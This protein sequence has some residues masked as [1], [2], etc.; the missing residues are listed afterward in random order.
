MNLIITCA[1]HMEPE[2]SEEICAI[3]EKMG[4]PKASA[5]ITDMPGILT[6][7]TMLDPF[8]IIRETHQKICDEPWHIRYCLRMI[9]IQNTTK[10]DIK[11]I[12]KCVESIREKILEKDTYRISIEKRNSNV[13]SQELIINIA[14][15]IPNKVSLEKPDKTI[16]IEILGS[17]TGIAITQKGDVL[18]V[19]KTKRSLSE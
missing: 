5:T 7:Q 8:V 19:E 10:T 11:E 18:S 6:V 13:S 4:D 1:R 15:I 9:P 14:G 16:L 2:A 3:L 12:E 17:I